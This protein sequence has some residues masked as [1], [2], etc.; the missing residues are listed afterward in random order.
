MEFERAREF[1]CIAFCLGLL[2]MDGCNER[3][4][5]RQRERHASDVLQIED[6]YESIL[7]KYGIHRVAKR[8]ISEGKTVNVYR[9]LTAPGLRPHLE[10]H[11]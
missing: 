8:T 3:R 1:I 10:N 5:A 2:V 11:P 6:D 4:L 9:Q 7:G